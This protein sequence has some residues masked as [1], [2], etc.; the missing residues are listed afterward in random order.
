MTARAADA[1]LL[2]QQLA[3]GGALELDPAQAILV[4]RL[5]EAGLLRPAA[6]PSADR[7]RLAQVRAELAAIAA[8]RSAGGRGGLETA[9]RALRTESLEISERLAETEGATEVRVR[10]AGGP[11]RGSG[12]GADVSR[13][14]VTQQGRALLSD[15]APR[16]LRIGDATLEAFGTEMESLRRAFAWRAERA[17]EID[18][19][20]AWAAGAGPAS[21]RHAA[22][23]GLAAVRAEPARIARA[24]RATYDRLR[25]QEHGRTG[26]TAA[27]DASAAE[28][29]C[30]AATDL[31]AC[32]GPAAARWLS[33]YRVDLGRRFS[34]GS[35]EDALDAALMLSGTATAE[36]ERRLALG[37]Q[38]ATDV[39][40]RG[41]AMPL[42][43]ALLATA[44]DA[45]LPEHLGP[46]IATAAAMLA[47][48][49]AP[50][51]SDQMATAVLLTFVRG[52]LAAQIE[53]W[54]VLRQYLARFSPEGMAIAAALLS[55]IALEPAEVLDQLRLAAAEIQKR[56]LADGGAETMALAIKF[57]VSVAMLAAGTEGDHEESLALAPVIAPRAPHLGLHATLPVLPL[58]ATATAAFHR[59]ILDAAVE[60]ERVYQ[61]THS[62]YVF[63]RSSG[64]S[65]GWG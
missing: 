29:L 31:A 16:L 45:E 26:F 47:S 22:A 36:H 58:V 27:Q 59:P 8:A 35:T 14:H 62:S 19:A 25:S 13:Y 37:A 60:Y 12:M 65:H 42:S 52:D 28:C 17:A 24:F 6:D 10:N 64:R 9:E 20:I 3:R 1:G 63:G 55:W 11:Y 41:G 53:R 30:L 49:I 34:L 50:G 54:R 15:L 7:G 48:D 4:D 40:G 38:L 18:R 33:Q 46:S 61:Q 56:R 39:R 23:I 44:A 51:S 2:L 57:L 32:E 5:R 43:L 21:A